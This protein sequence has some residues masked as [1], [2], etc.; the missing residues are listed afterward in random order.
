ML[1]SVRV[2]LELVLKL[3]VMLEEGIRALAAFL[4]T[5]FATSCPVEDF[6]LHLLDHSYS[7]EVS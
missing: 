3:E 4:Q 6:H 2:E 1:D 7:G 5:S